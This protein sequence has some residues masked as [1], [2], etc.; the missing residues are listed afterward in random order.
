MSVFSELLRA[1]LGWLRTF[2]P[3]ELID[4]WEQGVELRFGQAVKLCTSKNGIRGS[5]VHF[6]WPVVGRV[7]ASEC[8]VEA[9]ETE[10]QTVGERTFT[11]GIQARIDDLRLYF[12]NVQDDLKATV[13]DTV[14]AAAGELALEAERLD[15]AFA[16]SVRELAQKRMRGWG[17]DVKRVSLITSTTAP[18]LRLIGA[19]RG[20]TSPELAP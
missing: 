12:T 6:Y 4:P 5:G 18:A 16:E 11:L 13:A 8:N 19:Q 9:W 2:W 17:V 3:F 7:V 10:P 20:G 15:T 14:R 1:L